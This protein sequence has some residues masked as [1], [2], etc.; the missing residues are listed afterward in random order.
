MPFYA[1][2]PQHNFQLIFKLKFYSMRRRKSH[3]EVM[4]QLHEIRTQFQKSVRENMSDEKSVKLS[5]K[6]SKLE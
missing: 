4:E 2:N 3:F 6:L 5:R 1:A